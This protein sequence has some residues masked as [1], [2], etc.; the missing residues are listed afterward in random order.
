[1]RKQALILVILGLITIVSSQAHARD[2][3]VY[4]AWSHVKCDFKELGDVEE[5]TWD[6]LD[7]D[8]KK[9]L[10][11]KL[12]EKARRLGA[13]GLVLEGTRSENY[14]SLHYGLG[15]YGS[16]DE[17]KLQGVAIKCKEGK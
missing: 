14:G 9:K 4:R 3:Q 11:E 1:M 6:E 10:K 16:M 5:G 2:V 8:E 17:T 7:A 15:F 13:D 12:V